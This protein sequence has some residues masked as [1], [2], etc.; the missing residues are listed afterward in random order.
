GQER[1]GLPQH[2][3]AALEGGARPDA[4][5]CRDRQ[6]HPAR[7]VARRARLR[8]PVRGRR[9]MYT[10]EELYDRI[11]H[12]RRRD[13]VGAEAACEALAKELRTDAAAVWKACGAWFLLQ[14]ERTFF[15]R[16]GFAGGGQSGAAIHAKCAPAQ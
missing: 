11:V 3:R 15:R 9:L 5:A 4:R 8:T 6:S 2:G 16:K 7:R 12:I 10:P 14:V 13:N 1:V